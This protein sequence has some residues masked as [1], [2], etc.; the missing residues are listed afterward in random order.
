MKLQSLRLNNNQIIARDLWQTNNFDWKNKE[1]WHFVMGEMSWNREVTEQ[2]SNSSVTLPQ[3]T[4]PL[5]WP[6]S[7]SNGVSVSF[8]STGSW[9][10]AEAWQDT[11]WGP[12]LEHLC[13]PS[14]PLA[15]A[16]GC[17]EKL[18]CRAHTKP[19][20]LQAQE[21]EVCMCTWAHR[22]CVCAVRASWSYCRAD[23]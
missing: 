17:R 3:V 14:A 16:V 5:S 9:I 13:D 19:A 4:P 1:A 10:P 11:C 2:H 21:T 8:D 20:H 6:P 12:H 18:G 22:R 15:P 23:V 7:G